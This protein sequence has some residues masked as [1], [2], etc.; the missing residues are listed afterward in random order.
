[1]LSYSLR[2][3][4]TYALTDLGERFLD[5]ESYK[6]QISTDVA[7]QIEQLRCQPV[8]FFGSGI[9]RR[10]FDAPNW[11]ELL[12]S[13]ASDCPLIDKDYAYYAQSCSSERQIGSIFADKYKDWA[14]STGK[15]QFPD[16]LFEPS[17]SPDSFLKHATAAVFKEISP[18]SL[19]DINSAFSDEITALQGI[20]PHAVLTTNYDTLLEV[21]FPDHAVIVG[22]SALKGMPFAVG[23]I[24][25]FHGCVD[26]IEQIVLTS[27]DYDAF[28]KKK[29]FIAARLLSL[30]N[31]HPMLIVGYGANDPNVQAFLSDIDE[32]LGLPGSLIENIYFVEYDAEAEGKNSLPTEKL[33]QIADNRSVRVKLIVASDF[34]W[35]FQ[36]FKSPENLHSVPP[37]FMRAILARSYE[38]VRTDMPRTQL[39]VDF[40]FL[41]GKLKNS[42]NFAK[43]FGITTVSDA[44]ALSA[45][46][47]YSITELGQKLGGKYWHIAKNQMEIIKKD[48][49]VDIRATDTKFHS[50]QKFNKSTFHSYSDDTLDLLKKVQAAKYCD[51][52]WL[53]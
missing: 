4:L 41:E 52:D 21:I 49:G 24:F 47:R 40:E 17:V 39:D 43:L 26:D 15:N 53:K 33:I 16:H 19:A 35:V 34:E 32:A 12:Q 36:A 25:K 1:M 27:E 11:V 51:P 22:Q 7:A 29:K 46:F 50:L 20:K 45:K 30:F 44:S 31:E 37:S 5:Y 3:L 8:L 18:A 13:L 2:A 14:W 28:T 10:Y 38:L 23:E 42:E 6:N 9:S 48:T